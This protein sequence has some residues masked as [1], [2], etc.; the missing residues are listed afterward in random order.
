MY[1]EYGEE[2]LRIYKRI[3]EVLN[4]DYNVDIDIYTIHAVIKSYSR[5]IY[6]GEEEA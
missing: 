6:E 1:A 3:K 4:V 2:E 5:L